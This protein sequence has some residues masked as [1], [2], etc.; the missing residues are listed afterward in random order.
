MNKQNFN[1]QKFLQPKKT[2]TNKQIFKKQRSK[3]TKQKI[4]GTNKKQTNIP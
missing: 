1:Y 3:Q 2:R 4:K